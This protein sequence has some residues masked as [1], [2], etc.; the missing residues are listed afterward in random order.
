MNAAREDGFGRKLPSL[1][2]YPSPDELEDT[3]STAEQSIDIGPSFDEAPADPVELDRWIDW[4]L[5]RIQQLV[6]QQKKNAEVVR[7]EIEKLTEWRDGENA[8]LQRSI[9]WFEQQVVA[10]A[11]GYDFGDKKSRKLPHGTFGKRLVGGRTVITD[12]AAAVAFA[13]EKGVPV[14]VVESVMVSDIKEYIESTGESLPF[15]EQDE[16]RDEYYVKVAS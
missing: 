7:T 8:S 16:K 10:A 5:R 4:R 15:V 12:M 13:R 9:D 11:H 6:Q 2:V 14:K 3:M 1:N